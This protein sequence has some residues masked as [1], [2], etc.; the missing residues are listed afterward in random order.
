MKVKKGIVIGCCLV[1]GVAVF[2]FVYMWSLGVF[3]GSAAFGD[4][5]PVVEEAV[6]E[7]LNR[8]LEE[9]FADHESLQLV[10]ADSYAAMYTSQYPLEDY[11]EGTEIADSVI[12]EAIE[13]DYSNI[14]IELTFKGESL[15]FQQYKVLV[16]D[17]VEVIREKM[18]WA[19]INMQ[20]FYNRYAEEGESEDVLQYESRIPN[21]L[22]DKDQKT[23]VTSSGTHF[24]VEV[25]GELETKTK[26][27]YNVK[28]IY[29]AVVSVTVIALT[30]L[31]IVRTLRKKR[32]YNNSRKN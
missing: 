32:R 16:Y 27:Y 7:E 2:A 29:L 21:Y 17:I 5:N 22:F 30:T 26:I 4:R 20:V 19:P 24:V 15:E 10:K 8:R 18:D 13:K 14:T 25:D 23:V 31:L 1:V 3:S 6:I 28:Y 11:P 9:A 12:D